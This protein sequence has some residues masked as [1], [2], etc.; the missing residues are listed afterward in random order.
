MWLKKSYLILAEAN[1]CVLV[2]E[3]RNRIFDEIGTMILVFSIIKDVYPEVKNLKVIEHSPV[4][5]L[6]QD[7]EATLIEVS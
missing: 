2:V 5:S 3:N 4:I 7:E 6:I 1:L